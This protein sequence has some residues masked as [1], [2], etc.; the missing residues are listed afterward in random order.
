MPKTVMGYTVNFS[1][2]DTL[3]YHSVQ[4]YGSNLAQT[5]IFGYTYDASGNLIQQGNQDSTLQES[6][7]QKIMPELSINNQYNSTLAGNLLSN[8]TAQEN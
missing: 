1:P 2:S 8:Q 7:Q 3:S 6:L 5:A 4:T